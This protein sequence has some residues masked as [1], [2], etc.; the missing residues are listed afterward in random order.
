MARYIPSLAPDHWL[1]GTAFPWL[2]SHGGTVPLGLRL[3]VGGRH[4]PS[5][6]P[7]TSWEELRLL[8]PAA[9]SFLGENS[10][11]AHSPALQAGRALSCVPSWLADLGTH[12]FLPL[13]CL[14][15]CCM[16]G[17]LRAIGVPKVNA[18]PI[19]LDPLCHTL[20]MPL[21]K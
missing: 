9:D 11:A 12:S 6:A 8:L 2:S 3:E 5:L 15:V 18:T 16:G 19:A 14:L 4:I 10:L 17:G 20:D 7:I 21:L 1:G 13:Q